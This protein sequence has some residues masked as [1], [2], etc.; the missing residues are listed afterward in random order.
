MS[1]APA[2]VGGTFLPDPTFHDVRVRDNFIDLY[3]LEVDFPRH[4]E[5]L[6]VTVEA[7]SGQVS[8]V[9]FGLDDDVTG[10]EGFWACLSVVPPISGNTCR[11][12]TVNRS[13]GT[14][15]F[16]NTVLTDI[17]GNTITLNGTVIFRPF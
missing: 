8:V 4:A 14:V 9:S 7:S 12:V 11:G 13:A 16:S 2:S 5:P 10:D 15:T 3:A 6:N 17:A 1:N